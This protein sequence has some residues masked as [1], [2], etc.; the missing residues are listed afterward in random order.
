MNEGRQRPAINGKGIL[1]II[2]RSF[3]R[4]PRRNLCLYRRIL[5]QRNNFI[6]QEFNAKFELDTIEYKAIIFTKSSSYTHSDTVELIRQKH[7]WERYPRPIAKLNGTRYYL[8]ESIIK[9][10]NSLETR[11]L[12]KKGRQVFF[13]HLQMHFLHQIPKCNSRLIICIQKANES[14]NQCT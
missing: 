12:P 8:Q 4:H 10:A 7:H 6:F 14:P 9:S 13:Q 3:D 5:P 11:K 2:A 1:V